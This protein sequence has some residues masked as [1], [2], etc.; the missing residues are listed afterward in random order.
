VLGLALVSPNE[1]L[2][3]PAN[4]TF[5]DN[6]VDEAGRG[7]GLGEVVRLFSADSPRPTRVVTFTDEETATVAQYAEC[8]AHPGAEVVPMVG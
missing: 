4:S 2:A 6:H 1:K 7:K 5:L 3:G 8:F